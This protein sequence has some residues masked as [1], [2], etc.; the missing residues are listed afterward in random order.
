ME[1]TIMEQCTGHS[2]LVAEIKSLKESSLE[3]KELLHEDREETK[4][5]FEKYDAIID[6][7]DRCFTRLTDVTIKMHKDTANFFNKPIGLAVVGAI[8]LVVCVTIIAYIAPSYLV[9]VAKASGKILEV[10]K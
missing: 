6:N 10:I 9:P 4:R 5:K 2:G 7:M 3:I 1:R 8:T